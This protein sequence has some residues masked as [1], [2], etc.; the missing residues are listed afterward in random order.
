MSVQ[1][2]LDSTANVPAALKARFDFVP[3]TVHF[4]DR[5]Y[6]DGVTLDEHRF[7]EMLIESDTLPTT[8]HLGGSAVSRW[9]CSPAIWGSEALCHS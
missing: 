2:I 8:S 4:G 7:Y 1:I 6:L 3:L 5:E 9:A